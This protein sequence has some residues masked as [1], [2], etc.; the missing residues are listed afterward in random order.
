MKNRIGY[1]IFLRYLDNIWN[2]EEHD[3]LGGLLGGMSLLSDGSTADPAYGYMW[4]NAAEKTS[5]SDDPYQISIQFLKDYLALGYID[6]IGQ[7]LSDMEAYVCLDLWKKAKYDVMHD[8]DDP[9]L[10]L[11]TEYSQ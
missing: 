6:E 10:N 3:W 5:V 4:D 2:A 7:V 11:M 9:Y 1:R 8:S